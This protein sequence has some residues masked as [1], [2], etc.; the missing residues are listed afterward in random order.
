MEMSSSWIMQAASQAVESLGVP[1]DAAG[2]AGKN[3][4]ED[5]APVLAL[6]SELTG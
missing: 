6:I 2:F 1:G 3:C 5:Y 4:L